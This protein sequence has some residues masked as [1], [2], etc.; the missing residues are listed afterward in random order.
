M[1]R[2]MTSIRIDEDVKA[3]A[4]MA[5]K[6]T[7][8]T[9]AAYYEDLIL[10]DLLVNHPDLFK[11]YRGNNSLVKIP[12]ELKIVSLVNKFCLELKEVLKEAHDE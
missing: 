5:A 7:N 10:K 1:G 4:K 2:T 11:L 8:F 6:R 9:F 12:E 3:C